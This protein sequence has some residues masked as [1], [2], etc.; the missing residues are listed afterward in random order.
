ARHLHGQIVVMRARVKGEVQGKGNAGLWLR[1]NDATGKTSAF[2]SSYQQPISGNTGWE[3]R[4]ARLL[5]GPETDRLLFGALLAAP[6]TL[7]VDNIE[8]QV[9]PVQ[10][11]EMSEPARGYLDTAIALIADNAYYADRVDWRGLRPELDKL[12]SGATG[13]AETYPA[14]RQALSAL[15]D[16]HS[17]LA[18]P[19]HVDRLSSPPAN[20]SGHGIT[21]KMLGR[22]GY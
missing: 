18:L 2:S 22:V 15:G 11:A 4:E 6:G 21:A 9:L 1:G 19:S 12:A 5:V 16:G 8:L 14:I 10:S 13:P 17:H 3:V 7:W 20:I